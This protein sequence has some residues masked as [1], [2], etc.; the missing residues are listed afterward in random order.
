M[1]PAN[2]NRF[3]AE[4]DEAIDNHDEGSQNPKGKPFSETEIDVVNN[5]I[6]EF[7]DIVECTETSGYSRDTKSDAW[8]S[9]TPRFNDYMKVVI[10]NPFLRSDKRLRDLWNNM[11]SVARKIDSARQNLNLSE[12]GNRGKIVLS[13]RQG[14]IYTAV[15]KI[16]PELD[17]TLKNQFDSTSAYERRVHSNDSNRG[18]FEPHLPS[19]ETSYEIVF[20]SSTSSRPV[21]KNV[22][23]EKNSSDPVT[24]N[25]EDPKFEYM[26]KYQEALYEGKVAALDSEKSYWGIKKKSAVIEQA[27]MQLKLRAAEMELAYYEVKYNREVGPNQDDDDNSI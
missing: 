25:Q 7:R 16:K 2:V 15:T 5:L 11:K 24:Q 19:N 6:F 10:K 27:V 1:L 21:L 17:F 9:I 20:D 3:I 22:T 8:R 4:L 13:P 14:A 26:R 23:H 12:T 18:D